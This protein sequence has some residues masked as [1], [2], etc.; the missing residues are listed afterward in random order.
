MRFW[1]LVQTT[2]NCYY[3][4]QLFDVVHFASETL[5]ASLAG[6]AV[7]PIIG[8]NNHQVLDNRSPSIMPSLSVLQQ[9]VYYIGGTISAFLSIVGSSLIILS[10]RRRSETGTYE[11]ILER[12]SWFDVAH[13][14]AL[15][16]MPYLTPSVSGIWSIGTPATCAFMGF[17]AQMGQAVYCYSNS[18]NTFYFMVVVLG[19]RDE[20]VA[21]KYEPWFHGISI[22]FPLVTAIVGAILRAYAPSQLGY[23]CWIDVEQHVW[24]GTLFAFPYFLCTAW[25]PISNVTI[26]CRVRHVMRRSFSNA[27]VARR[28]KDVAIQ[29]TLYVLA[30]LLVVPG[31]LIIKTQEKNGVT[32]ESATEVYGALLFCQLCYPLLGLSNFVI[33]IRPR[34]VRFRRKYA[35]EGRWW[36]LYNAVLARCLE[37]P[38]RRERMLRETQMPTLSQFSVAPAPKAQRETPEAATT[39]EAT[40]SVTNLYSNEDSTCSGD[41]LP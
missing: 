5:V 22:G 20:V 18:L 31:N 34:Y 32:S 8:T 15:V 10:V 1:V 35:D 41:S 37:A 30:V 28:T 21:R 12:M 14:S 17:M 2:D 11:R 29:A 23:S 24:L 13:S 38:C 33:F 3:K 27:A 39:E 26:Y 25:L 7:D 16:F 4:K 36:C 40:Q 6:L 9:R 19:I